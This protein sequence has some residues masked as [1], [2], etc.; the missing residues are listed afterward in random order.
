MKKPDFEV[1]E[2]PQSGQQLFVSSG[3]PKEY[4]HIAWG[5]MS[6]QFYGYIAGYKEAA[7][8]II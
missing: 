2:F 6:A 8:A 4:A 7:D 1:S 3:S 5:N